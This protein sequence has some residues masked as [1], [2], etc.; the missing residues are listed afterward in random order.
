[1][2][3]QVDDRTPPQSVW[4]WVALGFGVLT[5]TVLLAQPL[6]LELRTPGIRTWVVA[7]YLAP[8]GMLMLSLFWRH[9]FSA[10]VLFP[11]FLIP[12]YLLLPHLDQAFLGSPT[13]FLM[14]GA[15]LSLYMIAAA[16][17]LRS[18]P[19]ESIATP[20]ESNARSRWRAYRFH[21]RPR[22]VVLALTFALP[23]AG[24][25]LLPSVQS[26][27]EASYGAEQAAV[28]Q[29]MANLLLLF[30]WL[31]VA[32]LYYI[33]PGLNLEREQRLTDSRL[34]QVWA[35]ASGTSTWQA[36]TWSVV[37]L[38]LALIWMVVR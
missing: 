36:L 9:W 30:G 5:W 19:E 8:L 3:A 38:A 7:A 6:V 12:G 27:L 34:E 25:N 20:L 33:G 15:S 22:S 24:L 35:G 21:L 23:F 1:M 10:L 32:F 4:A 18:H 17:Q 29:T 2:Q 26:R 37:A 31:A 13:G 16:L 28:A 11:L 14:C